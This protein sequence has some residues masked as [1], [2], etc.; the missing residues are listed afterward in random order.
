MDYKR[1]FLNW[2]KQYGIKEEFLHNCRTIRSALWTTG[3][4][5][6]YIWKEHP[7]MYILNS[8][9]WD[10]SPEGGNFWNRYD[11]LWRDFI[12]EYERTHS[13][14]QYNGLFV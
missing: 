14:Q 9:Y 7:F 6:E 2:L 4:P 1:L 11:N 3:Y 10:D 5:I 13:L 12:S 8:F